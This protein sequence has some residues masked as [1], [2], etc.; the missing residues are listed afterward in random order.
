[1]ISILGRTLRPPSS[2]TRL[3]IFV[4]LSVLIMVLDHKGSYGNYIRNT[5]NTLI[6]PVHGIASLPSTVA[7]WFQEVTRSEV[8]YQAIIKVLEDKNSKLSYQ[9]NRR[10]TLEDE[11]KR[12]RSQLGAVQRIRK[13]YTPRLAELLKVSIDPYTRKLYLN[14]GSDHGVFI[15]QPVVDAHGVV[16]QVSKV[17]GSKAVVTLIIDPS[18]AIPVMVRRNGLRTIAYGTGNLDILSIPYLGTG[19]RIKEKDILVTSGMGGIFPTGYPVGR[20]KKIIKD[21]NEP[22]LNITVKPMA[23][24]NYGKEVLLLYP[25]TRV[26]KRKSIP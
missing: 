7:G 9:L 12:L 1:M 6:K 26:G 10:Q 21:P 16:G 13:D 14:Q 19:S 15:R 22:F 4:L 11:N 20:V 23:R 2:L 5:I 18:H 24:I 3:I 25:K 17:Y 8:D